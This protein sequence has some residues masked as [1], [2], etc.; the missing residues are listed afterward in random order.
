MSENEN[1]QVLPSTET[2]T[3][4]ATIESQPARA[5][6]AISH[7]LARR[8]TQATRDVKAL[9]LDGENEFHHYKYPT[10]AQVRERANQ[11]LAAAGISIVPSIVRVARSTRTSDKG[12]TISITAIEMEFAVCS[13]DGSFVARWLGESEDSGDKGIQKAASAA[14]KAFLSNLLL[15]PVTEDEN[16]KKERRARRARSSAQMQMRVESDDDTHKMTKS[17]PAPRNG[18]HWIENDQ[19]RKRFWAWSSGELGL[20]DADVY[21][22][23]GVQHIDEFGGTMAEAKLAIEGYLSKKVSE[24]GKATATEPKPAV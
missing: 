13:E 5:V 4:L 23:L 9:A 10:I 3:A 12:K 2:E 24:I 1:P 11:A 8:L 21:A 19:I 20:N 7:G 22:A 15:I 17:A 14:V 18:A 6:A 16:D